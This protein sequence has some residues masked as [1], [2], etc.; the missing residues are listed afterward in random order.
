MIEEIIVLIVAYILG[1]LPFG[2]W[3]TKIST[4]KNLLEVGWKKNSGSNVF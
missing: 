2:Y 1:S 4:N 3:I